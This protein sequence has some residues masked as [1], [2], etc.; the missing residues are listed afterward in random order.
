MPAEAH[1]KKECSMSEITL[2]QAA[3][4]CGAQYDS[5]YADVTFL[6]ASNDSR[7]LKPGELFVALQGERDGHAYI[8]QAMAAGAAAVLC[9]RCGEDIPALV[10]DDPRLALGKIAKEERLRLGCRVVGVTG[11]VGKST[12]KEMIYTILRTRFR[13]GKTPVN[14][15]NDLGMPMSILALPRDTQVAV[16]EMG[17]NHF[18]EMAY[19][20]SIAQPDVAVI[21]NIGTMHIEHLG[22]REGILHAKMEILEGLRPGGVTVFNGDEPLL[23]NLREK[24]RLHPV[25][26]GTENPDNA[27]LGTEVRTEDG[28]VSF[29]AAVEGERFEVRL[30]VEGSH[31]VPDALAAIAVGRIFGVSA[32]EIAESLSGFHTMAGRMEKYETAGYVIIKDCYN[33]GP[34]S[35]KASL[36]VLG[37]QPGRR[38]A[39]LGDMLELG[40]RTQAEH[41]RVGRLAA[42]KADLVFALGQ[43]ASRIVN[44]AVTGGM[45]PE[46][47]LAFTDMQE[48]VRALC[49]KAKPGDVLLFKGSRG[50][51]MEK[52][53]ERFLTEKAAAPE[54][55]TKE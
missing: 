42:C 54:P 40:V 18:R 20:T 48:L 7:T 21:T 2:A 34:E 35:M 28:G 52:A 37:S 36:G 23:W 43:N 25:F 22:S 39:V 51:R 45:D 27:V 33:A 3:A 15:N 4:W 31:F 9:S 49:R 1:G 26:F 38:I 53:L 29:L 55:D 14:R 50:M 17:M 32:A 10:V 8:P 12:T 5:K 30:P 19:L 6:G 46:K 41:Y 16:L 11:S 24:D 47:A 13:T 44:G